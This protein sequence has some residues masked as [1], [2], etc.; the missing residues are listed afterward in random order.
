MAAAARALVQKLSRFFPLNQDELASIAGLEGRRRPIT[1]HTEIVHE[2]QEGHHAFIRRK[3]GRA[4]TS[5]CPTA[6]G[7]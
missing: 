3:A 5:C 6:A 1:A 7:R 2:R 4:R